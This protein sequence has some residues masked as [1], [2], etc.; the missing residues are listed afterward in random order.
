MTRHTCDGG[1][2]PRS[3]ALASA[4]TFADSILLD[5]REGLGRIDQHRGVAMAMLR[6]SQ[7]AVMMEVHYQMSSATTREPLRRLGAC[8]VDPREYRSSTFLGYRHHSAGL[9][10]RRRRR[11]LRRQDGDVHRKAS[12]QL[13]DFRLRHVQALLSTDG[14]GRRASAARRRSRRRSRRLDLIEVN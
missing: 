11:L 8:A 3:E 9:S 10:P 5:R 7:I 14:R 4:P 12:L 6:H 1:V 13:S 2:G